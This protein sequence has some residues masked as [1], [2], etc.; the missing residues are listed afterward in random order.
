MK[1]GSQSYVRMDTPRGEG[2][3]RHSSET[4]N[5]EDV[6]SPLLDPTPWDPRVLLP[7]LGNE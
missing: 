6:E 7:Q 1:V 3:R 5:E 4:G 2:G